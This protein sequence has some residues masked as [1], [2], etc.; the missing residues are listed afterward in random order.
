MLIFAL[1][2]IVGL[3]IGVASLRLMSAWEPKRP[4]QNIHTPFNRHHS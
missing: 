1:C 4:V 2:F 3:L